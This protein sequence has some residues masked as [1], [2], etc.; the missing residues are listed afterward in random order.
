MEGGR[1]TRSA[2]DVAELY[3]TYGPMVL[4]R[5]QHFYPPA[6]AEEVFQEVFLQV[7]EKIETFRAESSASTWLYRLATNHCINRRRNHGRRQELWVEF[8]PGSYWT[9]TSQEASQEAKLLLRELWMTLPEDLV[10]VGTYYYF[11]GMTH[12][13]IARLIGV[14]RR[15]VGNRLE[16]LTAHIQA[17]DQTRQGKLAKGDT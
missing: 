9:R 12:A 13:E 1:Q 6:E 7:V 8:S 5:I 17:A 15:T 3:R 16:E 2:Q 11:D 4:R 14:S 10:Q